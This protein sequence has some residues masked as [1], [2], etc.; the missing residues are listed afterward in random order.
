QK[1]TRAVRPES[2]P[3]QP[4]GTSE[5]AAEAFAR[6]VTEHYDDYAAAYPVLDELR[7]LA[8]LTALA[9]WLVEQRIPINT[10]KVFEAQLPRVDTPL[11]TPMGFSELVERVSEGL[12]KHQVRGGVDLALRRSSPTPDRPRNWFTGTSQ[13]TAQFQR[14]L[15][16]QKPTAPRWNVSFGGGDYTAVVIAQG[17][18]RQAAQL[19]KKQATAAKQRAKRR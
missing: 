3:P 4:S 13:D 11:T 9:N 5:P 12:M 16:T 10:R 8:K 15:L 17:Q 2:V 6:H 1:A 19:V 7:T 18:V 14:L